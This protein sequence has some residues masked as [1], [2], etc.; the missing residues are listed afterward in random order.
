MTVS[1]KYFELL[2]FLGHQ[3]ICKHT[4]SKV[5]IKEYPFSQIHLVFMTMS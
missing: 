4:Y 2:I 3:C 5:V 1:V